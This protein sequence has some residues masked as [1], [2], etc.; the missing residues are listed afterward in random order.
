[1]SIL[2]TGGGGYIGS[3]AVRA[4]QKAGKKVIVLDN[5]V[6]GHREVVEKTLAVPLVIGQ[7]GNKRLLTE[8]LRGNYSELTSKKNGLNEP[9]EAVMHF[10]AYA[11]VGESVTNPAKYYRNN[12]GDSLALLEAIVI[13]NQRRESLANLPS[14]SIV[15][16]STCATYGV[17]EKLPISE[18]TPTEPI[19]PYGRSKRMVEQLLEDFGVAYGLKSIIFR[20]FNAAGAD[21]EGDLGESHSPETHLIPLVLDAI[22]GRIPEIKVYG[23][24]YP[25]KDGTCIRDFIHVTDLANAHLLGLEWLNKEPSLKSFSPTIFNLGTGKGYSVQEVINAAQEITGGIL[26][27]KVSSRRAGDPPIL[28]ASSNK[29]YSTL[30]WKPIYSDL[31]TILQHAWRWHC[32]IHS[33]KAKQ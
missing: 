26:K 3:H 16:S 15:F 21:P 31:N 2:V 20:Y 22:T 30:N 8:L 29:A 1:M 11:Y 33:L 28:V 7:V 18:L 9:V 24:D 10:A 23:D 32:Q 13:E 5:L 12:V 14:I 27:T 25:T 19:N 4:L 6:H 17:P